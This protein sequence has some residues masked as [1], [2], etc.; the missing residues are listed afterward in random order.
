M[1]DF[2]SGS[3]PHSIEAQR[4][5]NERP[6]QG[7]GN[8]TSV[9]QDNNDLATQSRNGSASDYVVT[10]SEEAQN[11]LT[12]ER[13][14]EENA[15][16]DQNDANDAQTDK[17]QT[18][19]TN[20]S[21]ANS[22]QL[23]EEERA[24][25]EDMKARDQE[26]RTHEQAHAATGGQYA[27]SPSYSYEQGPDGKRYITD[28]EVQIDVSAVA[29][30]PQATIDKMKQVYRAAL[31]PAE[32]SGADRS[33]ASE[34]QQKMASAMSELAQSNSPKET[35][36]TDESAPAAND[37]VA[38]QSDGIQSTQNGASEPLSG[39]ST[40]NSDEGKDSNNNTNQSSYGSRSTLEMS[41]VT[42]GI[43]DNTGG[44]INL[45]A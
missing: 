11:A 12:Q 10:L 31:A 23:S 1:V 35:N 26:V 4:F 36:N 16:S 7:A 30:D 18:D 45:T 43:A 34:A 33:V 5:A 38:P 9:A 27:G 3:I 17:N 44:L 22:E 42:K 24:K 15:A 8:A 37:D 29:G 25:V 28:G 13:A 6:I 19:D 20:D 41:Y 32:P 2:M 21:K 39:T 40:E 14:R